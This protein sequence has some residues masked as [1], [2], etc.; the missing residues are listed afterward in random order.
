MD[1]ESQKKKKNKI[2]AHH[3]S[4]RLIQQGIHTEW[5]HTTSK[6]KKNKNVHC[7]HWHC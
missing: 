2:E 1:F 5:E 4:H 3:R 6:D 7:S